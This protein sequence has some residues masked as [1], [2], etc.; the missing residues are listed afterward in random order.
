MTI[1]EATRHLKLSEGYLYREI[2][3]KRFP[4]AVTFGKKA[5]R[6]SVP[7]LDEWLRS[8]SQV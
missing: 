1:H 4:P 7:L 2:R 3:A 5:I 8:Q 6:I